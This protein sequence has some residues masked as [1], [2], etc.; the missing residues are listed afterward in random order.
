LLSEEWDMLQYLY[1]H[2]VKLASA[3]R[4]NVKRLKTCSLS[5]A[6]HRYDFLVEMAKIIE[7]EGMGKDPS[8]ND[9]FREAYRCK[10]LQWHDTSTGQ[11]ISLATDTPSREGMAPL[12]VKLALDAWEESYNTSR[13]IPQA[14][15]TLDTTQ[16]APTQEEKITVDLT[17][18]KV[19]Y[20]K[21]PSPVA[22][23]TFFAKP[24]EACQDHLGNYYDADWNLLPGDSPGKAFAKAIAFDKV[25]LDSAHDCQAKGEISPNNILITMTENYKAKGNVT[26]RIR[27]LMGGYAFYQGYMTAGKASAKNFLFP[28]DT[29]LASVLTNAFN[30][31]AHYGLLKEPMPSAPA[32]RAAIDHDV[33]SGYYKVRTATAQPKGF[34]VDGIILLKPGS[35]MAP[36]PAEAILDDTSKI[37]KVP[38][39]VEKE[40]PALTKNALYAPFVSMLKAGQPYLNNFRTAA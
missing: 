28:K 38:T 9:F 3:M 18:V 5:D 27:A 23:P 26:W 33:K 2:K 13:N 8:F 10:Q 37:I 35:L 24:G 20:A 6:V 12:Y 21:K 39:N 7:D 34:S 4:A 32:T 15:E 14:V 25:M 17:N 16:D 36:K 1:R 11:K 19:R 30:R 31:G 40:T 22:N 29:E